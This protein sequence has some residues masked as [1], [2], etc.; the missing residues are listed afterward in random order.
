[1]GLSDLFQKNLELNRRKMSRARP[2]IQKGE[3]KNGPLTLAVLVSVIIMVGLVSL[4]VRLIRDPSIA[5]KLFG[6]SVSPEPKWNGTSHSQP[7]ASTSDGA[8]CYVPPEV[9][10]YRKLSAQDDTLSEVPNF[11]GVEIDGVDSDPES[12]RNSNGLESDRKRGSTTDMNSSQSY[13]TNALPPQKASLPEPEKGAKIFTVQVGAFT[14]PGI[15]Q[16][17]ALKWKAKGYDVALK[18]VARPRTGVIYRLY[19]GNFSSEKKAD[20]LVKHL[21]S[22]EGISSFPVVLRN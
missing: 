16:E 9:T 13:K 12:R 8:Q 5:E 10:F 21:K 19:L 2:V 1:M 17:W 3:P 15:A 14:H 20:E 11:T 18:P 4:N 7:T 6:R 22:K